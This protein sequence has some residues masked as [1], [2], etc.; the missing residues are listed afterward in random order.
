M[1][2]TVIRHSR[3]TRLSMSLLLACWKVPAVWFSP[4]K[5]WT[6][7][8]VSSPG[9][10]TITGITDIEGTV[11]NLSDPW[12]TETVE[13]SAAATT[14]AKCFTSMWFPY[15]CFAGSVT[16]FFS[17]QNLARLLARGRSMA[18]NCKSISRNPSPE[19]VPI[20]YITRSNGVS[21][22]KKCPENTHAPYAAR[23]G[24]ANMKKRSTQRVATS[25]LLQG[26]G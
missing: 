17:A 2:W 21:E 9:E 3:L 11:S 25:L 6:L 20:Q 8:V 18:T 5:F 16:D 13:T 22:A 14:R 15:W 12:A 24:I 19:R 7:A 10:T 23:V 26:A 1:T 4:S